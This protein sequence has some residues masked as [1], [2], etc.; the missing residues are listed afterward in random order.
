LPL[1]NGQRVVTDVN[2]VCKVVLKQQSL[3]LGQLV[4][5]II[6]L[7]HKQISVDGLRF[8]EKGVVAFM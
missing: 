1:R 3:K 8:D 5:P 6:T 4:Q 7:V 2:L